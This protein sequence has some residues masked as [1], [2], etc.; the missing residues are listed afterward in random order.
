MAIPSTPLEQLEA[1]TD[2]YFMIDGG[3]AKD[4]YFQTSFILNY[5]LKQKKGLFKR[6]GG[7]VYIRVPLRYD[8]NVSGFYTRGGTLSSDKREAITSLYFDWVHAYG[9]GTILRID[10]LKNNGGA[11]SHIDLITEEL[12]GAQAS[13][14]KTL[15]D[16]IYDDTGGEAG[17]LTGLRVMMNGTS[18]VDFG[19]YNEDDIVA[20]DGTTKVWAGKRTTTTESIGLSQIRDLKTTAEY[21]EGAQEEPNFCATTKALY[22]KIKAILQPQQMFTKGEVT[23]KAG[24]TGLSFEGSEIFPDKYC[25]SGWLFAVNSSHVGFAVHQN[26]NFVRTPWSI[27]EGSA[28]D[29]TMKILFDGNLIG[30]NRRSCAAHSN[31]S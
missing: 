6:P 2:D 31:L 23:A 25:P 27:I 24:F 18:T 3:K 12:Y 9:N 21:G 20:N 1:V 16:S 8:G 11:E 29:K 14:T 17:R 22:N 28:Q 26:G 7:G 19:G 5:L 13:V 10:T 4:L 30:N 15:A